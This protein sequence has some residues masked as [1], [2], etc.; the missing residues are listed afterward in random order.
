MLT[1]NHVVTTARAVLVT[2]ALTAAVLML[3]PWPG[4]SRCSD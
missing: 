1:P 2:G 4:W 3:G